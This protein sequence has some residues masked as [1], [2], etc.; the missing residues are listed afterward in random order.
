[1]E[2]TLKIKVADRRFT[3][4]RLNGPL[5]KPLVILVHGLGSSMQ[6]GLISHGTRWFAE[7]GFTTFR[8]DLYSWQKDARQLMDCT[9]RIHANDLDAVVAY[10]RQRGVKKIFVTGHSYG[11]P[12]VLLSKQQ[13]FDAAVLWDPSFGLSFTKSKY[14]EPPAVYVKSLNAYMMRWGVNLLMGKAMAKEA[15]NMAW[16]KLPE[17]FRVPLKIVAAGKGI[18]VPGAKQYFKHAHDPKELTIIK[19]AEHYFDEGHDMQEGVYKQSKDWF[20]R[21]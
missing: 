21:F 14:G 18:L 5:S 4:G 9:L 6:E 19:G 11:G 17:A 20:D 12:T 16:E 2:K 1:M 7:H 3:Y 10:F 15:D 13:A 8:F